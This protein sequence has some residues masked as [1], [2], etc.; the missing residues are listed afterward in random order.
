[1]DTHKLKY[2]FEFG[3]ETVET[4]SLRRPKTRDLR[5]IEE[6]E[7]K[8]EIEQGMLMI[9]ALTG[10]SPEAAD[11]LDAEDY[12]ALVERVGDFFPQAASADG[13]ASSRKPRTS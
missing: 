8:G 9:C 5:A 12:L 1:M 11:E 13:A 6:A 7:N 3:G 4:V 10:L 2:P